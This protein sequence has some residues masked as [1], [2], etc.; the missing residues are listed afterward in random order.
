MAKHP[1]SFRLDDNAREQLSELMALWGC[2][3]AGVVRRA[4]DAAY[5]T[6]ATGDEWVGSGIWKGWRITTEHSSSS[7][8]Q[9][10]LVGPDGCGRGP[11]DV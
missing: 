3:R 2:E 8:G 9:P 10:V 1:T 4:L 7:C 6:E 5:N 11:G